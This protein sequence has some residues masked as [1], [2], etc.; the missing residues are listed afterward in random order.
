M[1]PVAAGIPS[2]VQNLSGPFILSSM[3]SSILYGVL[4]LQV[5]T[6][7]LAFPKDRKLVK[8]LVYTLFLLDTAQT[9]LF[10]YDTYAIFGLG[11][12]DMSAVSTMHLDG[13][14]TPI[15]T[16]LTSAIVQSFYSYQIKVISRSWVLSVI[17]LLIATTQSLAAIIEGINTFRIDNWKLLPKLTLTPCTIW[18]VGSALCDTIIAVAMTFH[19]LRAGSGI[20]GSL[21]PIVTPLVRLVI[22]TGSL[23]ASVAIIDAVLFI[24][25]RKYPYHMIPAGSLAKLYSNALMAILNSRV[26]IKG[27]RGE[28]KWPVMVTSR[29]SSIQFAQN[30]TVTTWEG[31]GEISSRPKSSVSQLESGP[32]IS[33]SLGNMNIGRQEVSELSGAG[34]VNQ[35]RRNSV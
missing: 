26:R 22:E 33:I 32:Q 8:G 19:L 17:I 21:K 14:A 25:I 15:I 13:L 23:T 35:Y 7:Y 34:M 20:G 24:A 31:S 9:T 29:W 30:P 2:D 6:Y 27:C 16:G 12:G 11:F 10:F 5:Y 4:V 18:L 1:S 3:L 28:A